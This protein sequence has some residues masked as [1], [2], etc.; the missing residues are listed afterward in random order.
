MC[1]VGESSKAAGSGK[2]GR[3]G[4]GFK[5]VFQVSDQPLVVSP[6]FQ[7]CFDTVKHEVFGY[8]VPT[9]IVDPKALV[10]QQ[11]QHLLRRVCPAGRSGTLLVCPIARRVRGLDLMKD[12]SFDGLS[13]AFLKNLQ[14]ISFRSTLASSPSKRRQQQEQARSMNGPTALLPPSS[15]E[16]VAANDGPAERADGPERQGAEAAAAG[17]LQEY[18]VEREEV[19]EHGGPGQEAVGL[20]AVLKGVTVLRHRLTHCTIVEAVHGGSNGGSGSGSRRSYRLHSYTVS[21]GG[22]ARR[23]NTDLIFET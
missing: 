2:I 14:K 4:I 8:I 18:S 6:P 7:F 3:K 19:F 9:W 20:A 23:A 21:H 12:L 11:H 15:S 22:N 17:L 16:T 1:Q 13:L 10:P 5:S